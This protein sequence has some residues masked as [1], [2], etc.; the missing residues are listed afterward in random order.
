MTERT[1]AQ[2]LESIR[3]NIAYLK[4]AK[5]ETSKWLKENFPA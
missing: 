1:I 3:G 4:R 5:D 2:S